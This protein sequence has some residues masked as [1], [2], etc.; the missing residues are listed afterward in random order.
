MLDSITISNFKAVQDEFNSD[1]S[2]KLAKPLILN[3]LTKVNYLV[4][5]NGSG[6][7]SVL[8]YLNKYQ[9]IGITPGLV[10]KLNK[11]T[12]NNKTLIKYFRETFQMRLDSR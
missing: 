2:L 11:N 3:E 4:G 5:A 1:G 12:I 9:N 7:S 6:K 8:E 10:Y